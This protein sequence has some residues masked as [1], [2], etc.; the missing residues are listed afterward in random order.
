VADGHSWWRDAD[1]AVWTL[2]ITVQL[3]LRKRIDRSRFA[4]QW[5]NLF[6]FLAMAITVQAIIPR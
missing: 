5:Q 6:P 1:G 4:K 3:T 2:L